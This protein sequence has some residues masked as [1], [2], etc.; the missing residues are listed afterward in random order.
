MNTTE[1]TARVRELADVGIE[2]EFPAI[3]D[4]VIR[5]LLNSKLVSVLGKHITDAD[6][7]QWLQSQ[8][9]IVTGSRSKYRLPNRCLNGGVYQ[10]EIWDNGGWKQLDLVQAK[11][12]YLYNNPLSACLIQGDS[13]QV[14][15]PGNGL[16]RVWYYCRPNRMV[17]PQTA[18][19]ITAVNLSTREITLNAN[20]TFLLDGTPTSLDYTKTNV[21]IISPTGWNQAQ[22]LDM[23][24]VPFSQGI[25]APVGVNLEDIQVGDYVRGSGETD[26]AAIPSE[27][28]GMLAG[29]AAVVVA[30]MC[31]DTEKASQIANSIASEYQNFPLKL[32]PRVRMQTRRIPLSRRF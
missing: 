3:T 7:G 22:I 11:H 10:I 29:L 28:H 21:D 8:E 30:E 6:A 25:V 26:W 32:T 24:W 13:I 2:S 18:G 19:K 23:T 16:I 20:P 14:L 17:V 9:I 12:V 1:L 27:D 15:T 5:D 31:N 4:A